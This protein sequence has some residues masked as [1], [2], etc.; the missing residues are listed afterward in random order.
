[1]PGFLRRSAWLPFLMLIAILAATLP[2]AAQ[3]TGSIAGIVKDASGAVLPGVTVSVTGAAL[4]RASATTVSA[5]DGT[6]R[7]TLIPPGTY[8]VRFELSGFSA[9]TRRDVEVAINQQTT[10]DAAMAVGGVAES[11]DVAGTVPLVEV[12]R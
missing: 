3:V 7:L 8:E 4:Q 6:Y 11:V 12:N 1:M 9:V 10:I 5:P 2:A